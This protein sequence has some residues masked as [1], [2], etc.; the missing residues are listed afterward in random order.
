MAT[1]LRVTDDSTRADLEEAIGHLRARQQRVELDA[2]KAEIQAEIDALLDRI[3]L[4]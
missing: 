3:C 2:T 1:I 4:M